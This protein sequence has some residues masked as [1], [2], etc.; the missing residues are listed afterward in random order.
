AHL[1]FVLQSRLIPPTVPL[2]SRMHVRRSCATGRGTT[3]IADG[4]VPLSLFHPQGGAPPT[5]D[6]IACPTTARRKDA[7]TTRAPGA[8]VARSPSPL[9]SCSPWRREGRWRSR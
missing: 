9:C 4:A 3:A 8:D 6:V 2:V 1:P 7:G 5:W